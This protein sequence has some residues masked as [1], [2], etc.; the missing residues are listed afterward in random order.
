MMEPSEHRRSQFGQ[1]LQSWFLLFGYPMWISGS[2]PRILS[3]NSISRTTNTMADPLSIAASISGI[4][5]IGLRVSI[6]LADVI[7]DAQSAHSELTELLNDVI[8]LCE[9]LRKIEASTSNWKAS[10]A[11]PLLPG[12]F[13]RCSASMNDLYTTINTT[14]E[15]FVNGGLSKMWLQA[16]WFSRKKEIAAIATKITSYKSTLALTL[17]MQN[18]LAH[19]PILSRVW[20]Y[21]DI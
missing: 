11:D 20:N 21:P 4:L 18:A 10:T 14:Q 12:I 17:Q 13:E 15:A 16:T 5:G 8:M 9:I 19:L 7:S 2:L 3:N 6:T 1:V